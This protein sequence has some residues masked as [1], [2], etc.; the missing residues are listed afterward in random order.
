MS[1]GHLIIGGTIKGGTSSV[2]D[3]CCAHP[4]ICGSSTKETMFFT[5]GYSGDA[6]RDRRRYAGY[7]GQARDGQ[8]LVEASP[9]YLAF[10]DNVAPRIRAQLPE[11]KLLFILRNP[12]DRLYSYYHFARGKLQLA[13]D[14]PFDRYVEMCE[15]Y[16][17]GV[18]SASAAGI[19]EKHLRALEIGAYGR[20]L[21]NFLTVFPGEQIKVMFFEHLARDPR[22]FMYEL[23]D[24]A[25]VDPEF[26]ARHVFGRSNVT[27]SAKFRPAHHLAMGLNRTLEALLRRRPEFKQRLVRIYKRFNQRREGYAPM[28][29]ATRA[30]LAEYYAPDKQRLGALLQGQ[31]L[32]P[33][34]K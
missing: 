10:P 8:L 6:E 1:R 31:V 23:A 24:Y 26:Y 16:A 21:D 29:E 11:A 2:F 33:W 22:S 17:C 32:P 7:F 25:G 5:H 18:L 4:D 28:P 30:R 20:Y 3:Y 9:N 34:A 19:A 12:V 14:L 13:E 15:R 27:F